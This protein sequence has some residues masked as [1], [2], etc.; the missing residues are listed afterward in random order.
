MKIKQYVCAGL[1]ATGL[2]SGTLSGCALPL[3]SQRPVEQVYRL[4]PAVTPL[5]SSQTAKIN[6]YLPPVSVNPALDNSHIMLAVAGNRLD[7]IADSRWPDKLSDYL[8]AVAIDGLTMSNAFQSVSERMLGRE[9]N[10]RLLLRV[11]D[12]QA[13][14]PATFTPAAADDQNNAQ[15]TATVVISVEAFLLR[16]QD[17]RLIGQYRYKKQT[18]GVPVKTSRIVAAFEKTLNEVLANLAVDLAKAA[19]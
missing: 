11:T 12:F 5:T 16:V 10:Y 4:S 19:P 6:L 15:D 14:L 8:R 7:F 9:D 17:Q 13:E 2:L 3:K 18:A 1:L